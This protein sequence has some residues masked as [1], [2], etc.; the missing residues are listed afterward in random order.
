MTKGRGLGRGLDEIFLDNAFPETDGGQTATRLPLRLIDIRPNQPRKQFDEASLEELANSIAKNGVLQPILVRRTVDRYEIIA[1]ERRFR[2]AQAAGLTEIPAVAIEAT[3]AEA[4]RYAL[5]ENV[6][7]KDLNPHEEAAAFRQLRDEYGMTQEQ[8]AEDVGK[9][10]AAVANAMRLLELPDSVLEMLRDGTLTAG[11]GRALLGLKNPDKIPAVASECVRR[12]LSVRQLEALVKAENRQHRP[13]PVS[14]EPEVD[15]AASLE[16]R[17]RE[18]TGRWC[19]ITHTAKK[20]SIEIE[21]RDNEDLNEMLTRLF[22]DE[23]LR[24]Y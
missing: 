12:A 3:D 10:R 19:K 4:A 7:R 22:G 11:H 16:N 24:D 6:Q 8:I 20:K 9:S 17:L 1:G 18:E 5:I 23:V 14:A 2:A 15:Y 13:K 21:Y